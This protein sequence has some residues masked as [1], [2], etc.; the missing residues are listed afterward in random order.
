MHKQIAEMV[1]HLTTK[2]R[3]KAGLTLYQTSVFKKILMKG[4][5][6]MIKVVFRKDCH[7][8]RFT[9]RKDEVWK[10]RRKKLTVDGLLIRA[11]VA[12]KHYFKVIK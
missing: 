3:I 8:P 2:L 10:V 5:R 9:M 11:G 4:H 1:S 7:L 6:D 12:E